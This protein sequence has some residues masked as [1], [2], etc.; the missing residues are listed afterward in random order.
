[1]KI[2]DTVIVDF[3]HRKWVGAITEIMKDGWFRVSWDHFGGAIC[4]Y[5][6]GDL[7]KNGGWINHQES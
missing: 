7:V 4:A 2:G 1:M 3:G 5:R 6:I